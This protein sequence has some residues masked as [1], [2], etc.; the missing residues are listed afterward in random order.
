MTF[1]FSECTSLGTRRYHI[2]S[3]LRIPLAQSAHQSLSSTIV[4]L[5]PVPEILPASDSTHTISV[6]I[7]YTI[8]LIGY[9]TIHDT[10]HRNAQSFKYRQTFCPKSKS[11]KSSSESNPPKIR[12]I[13]TSHT[14][15]NAH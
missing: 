5:Y 12:E 6:A 11:C 13:H 1:E 4:R 8:H 7:W 3:L 14:L 2:I 9:H 10:L 15:H